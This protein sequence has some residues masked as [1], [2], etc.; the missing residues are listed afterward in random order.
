LRLDGRNGA[1]DE[2]VGNEPVAQYLFNGRNTAAFAQPRIHDHQIRPA[3]G[4]RG[5]GT[6]LSGFNSRNLIAHFGENIGQQHTDQGIVLDDENAQRIHAS[7]SPHRLM[8]PSLSQASSG[9][10]WENT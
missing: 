6:C 7:A 1:A 9:I 5:H 4:R 8:P 10:S 3:A 2:D